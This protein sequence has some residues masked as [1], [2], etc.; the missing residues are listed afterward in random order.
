MKISQKIVKK[1]QEGGPMPAG[2]PAGAPPMEG[3]P[4]QGAAPEADPIMQ[5]AELA[6]QALQSQDCQAAMA[7]CEGFVSLLQGPPDAG[8]GMAPAGGGAPEG[9]PVFKKGG[10]LAKRMKANC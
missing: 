9:A 2:E 6:M 7:V 1:F 3:A 10:K 4:E 5:I 8:G